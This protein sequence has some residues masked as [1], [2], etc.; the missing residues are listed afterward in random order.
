MTMTTTKP[1]QVYFTRNSSGLTVFIDGRS[2]TLSSQHPNYS[3][4]LEALRAKAYGKLQSLMNVTIALEK[5]GVSKK[6]PKRRIYVQ[7]GKIWYSL[8]DGKREEL[9][10]ALAKKVL[11]DLHDGFQADNLLRFQ[12]KLYQ[13]PREGVKGEL[14]EWSQSGNMV[15]CEDGDFLAYK[16]V[17]PSFKDLYT[18][19]VNNS[20][21]QKLPRLKD[22]DP[23]RHHT[24]STGY[25]FCSL[26]Y[27]SVYG[28]GAENKVVI[29][30]V[31]PADVGAIPTD[32]NFQ[33]GRAFTYEVIGEYKGDHKKDAFARTF[34]KDGEL[35]KAVKGTT[36]TPDY[37]AGDDVLLKQL[38]EED[39]KEMWTDLRKELIT[40]DDRVWVYKADEGDDWKIVKVGRHATKPID[41][42]TGKQL[43]YEK[44]ETIVRQLS[45]KTK[46][47]VEALKRLKTEFKRIAG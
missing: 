9:H 30:K 19:T 27:L 8:G 44:G 36:F 11:A 40:D 18:G 46:S 26:K 21:G 13:N 16:K 1:T 23:N 42:L 47:A 6:D 45:V 33:K 28:P 14:Y 4:V 37:A 5:V 29:V 39:V 2:T 22:V 34:A 17:G 7:N 35:E 10:G 32:Y 15:I 25:H 43:P 3:K 31:N 12:E 41:P 20:P 24:C 38:L